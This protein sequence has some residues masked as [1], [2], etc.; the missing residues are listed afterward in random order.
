MKYI[1]LSL[2]IVISLISCKKDKFVP[3][4]PESDIISG[5]DTLI[6][7][8]W[9]YMYSFGG[10]GGSHIDKGDSLLTLKPMRDF[11]SISKENKIIDGRIVFK[12]RENNWTSI[13]FLQDGI[14]IVGY[15]QSIELNGPDS[16]ILHDPCCDMYSDI[17]T[18][19]K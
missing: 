7:G 6:Y 14:R 9:R 11:I 18:R 3:T 19:I 12:V 17:F 10:W 4:E 13:I 16:L 2:L 5:T 15:P 8:E 1:I